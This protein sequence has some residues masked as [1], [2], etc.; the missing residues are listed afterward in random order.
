MN[1]RACILTVTLSTLFLLS[2][3]LA[4]E[5]GQTRQYFAQYGLTYYREPLGQF[6]ELRSMFMF[7]HRMSSNTH[8]VFW[9]VKLLRSISRY[10][11]EG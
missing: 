8:S 5:F 4:G 1:L 2:P 11:G 3:C 7:L 9:E 6:R 10:F